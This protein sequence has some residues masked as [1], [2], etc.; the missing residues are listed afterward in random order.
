[1]ADARRVLVVDDEV[2]LAGVIGSYFT[3]DGYV[4]ALAHSGDAA[5]DTALTFNPDLVVLDVMLPGLDGLEVCRV[6][7]ER[8]DCYIIM[9]TAREAE[10]DKV[11]ALST[12]ADD[13][14]VKPCSP[15]ELLARA[16]A[17]L[18]RP[19]MHALRD[20]RRAITVG[21]LTL[22]TQAR[23]ADRAG[24]LV[25]LTRTEFDILAALAA[26]PGTAM[27]RKQIIEAV[28]GPGWYGD[29]QVVDVHVAAIRRKLNDSAASPRYLRTV[30][31]VGYALGDPE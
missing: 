8:S 19:R 21:D 2:A 6:L 4:V 5:I 14:V 17:M 3:R 1:M 27:S 16:E 25:D 29:E 18:R 7:R 13:Y 23:M 31:G 20:G 11:H 15:R 9:L 12:G 26:I 30:R 10:A 24:A 28:W 22:D